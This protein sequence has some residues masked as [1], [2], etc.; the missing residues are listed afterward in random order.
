[1]KFVISSQNK[2]SGETNSFQVAL[3]EGI[4]VREIEL[5]SATIPVAQYNINSTN[6]T[7]RVYDGTN[8]ETLTITPGFYT[9][10][11]LASAIS[12][13]FALGSVVSASYST[14]TGKITISSGGATFQIKHTNA[15]STA[16]E[17]LGFDTAAD[18]T[19]NT[20]YTADNLLGI[21]LPYNIFIDIDGF[22]GVFDGQT[23]HTFYV[24]ITENAGSVQTFNRFTAFEQTVRLDSER[25]VYNLRV[26]LRTDDNALYTL[27]GLN[28][29]ALVDLR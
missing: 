13:T 1:M 5:L 18:D 19:G 7:L 8:D 2:T 3:K 4:K 16:S 21:S 17:V 27:N 23:P 28:W 14:V 9:G 6:N 11:T 29:T 20:S 15:L 22:T 12:H 26:T 25:T 10:A 24:P